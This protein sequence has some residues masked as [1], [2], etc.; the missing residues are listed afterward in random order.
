[1]GYLIFW[2]KVKKCWG[3]PDPMDPPLLGYVPA[4]RDTRGQWPF[5]TLE[6]RNAKLVNRSTNHILYTPKPN[7]NNTTITIPFDIYN[8]SSSTFHRPSLTPLSSRVQY[9]SRTVLPNSL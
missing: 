9:A 3:E 7:K 5:E 2:F 4:T 8:E 6:F 1:M